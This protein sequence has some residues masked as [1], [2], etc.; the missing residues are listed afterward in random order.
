MWSVG[1]KLRWDKKRLMNLHIKRHPLL[2]LQ[3]NVKEVKWFVVQKGDSFRKLANAAGIGRD[4]LDKFN[5]PR[6]GIYTPNEDLYTSDIIYIPKK[7]SQKGFE[8]NR[9]H[10]IRVKREFFVEDD[11]TKKAGGAV[12]LLTYAHDPSFGYGDGVRFKYE[13]GALKCSHVVAFDKRIC[14]VSEDKR[15]T[16]KEHASFIYMDIGC[17]A[18]NADGNQMKCRNFGLVCGPH[19]Y[20]CKYIVE[21]QAPNSRVTR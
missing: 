14:D 17:W 18:D 8:T 3:I 11:V 2:S 16:I 21:R 12:P 20:L 5:W 4:A 10:T 19:V 6:E 9:V 13:E 1:S 7:W 15:A